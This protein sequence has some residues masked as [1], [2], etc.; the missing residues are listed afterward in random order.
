M[1]LELILEWTAKLIN[2]GIVTVAPAVERAIADWKDNKIT[3]EE[4]DAVAE[5]KFSQMAIALADPEAESDALALETERRLR[6]KFDVSDV[7]AANDKGVTS[8]SAAEEALALLRTLADKR[9]TT[10]DEILRQAIG[11][12]VPEK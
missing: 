3:A 2:F 5:G 8:V 6:K 4:A 11:A 9:G 12:P 7:T 1:T 10:V